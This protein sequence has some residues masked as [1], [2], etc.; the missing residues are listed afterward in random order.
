MSNCGVRGLGGL[1]PEWRTWS[2]V[3]GVWF[4]SAILVIV[5]DGEV[6]W[7]SGAMWSEIDDE[8]Y[9]VKHHIVALDLLPVE[10]DVWRVL[11]LLYAGGL[12]EH[13]YG[14][15]DSTAAT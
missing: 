6:S 7:W 3:E 13:C 1:T 9:G 14:C 15:G 10:S 8:L 5:C 4:M 11:R 12:G 2:Y